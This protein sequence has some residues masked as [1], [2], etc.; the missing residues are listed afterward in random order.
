MRL[1]RC[2]TVSR[3]RRV[4]PVRDAGFGVQLFGDSGFGVEP[5]WDSGF[6]KACPRCRVEPVWDSGLRERRDPVSCQRRAEP[7][8][9][10]GLV[11]KAHRLVYHSTLGSRVIKRE[12][13]PALPFA[14]QGMGLRVQ[15]SGRGV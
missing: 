11:S 2:D 7:A 6:S 14:I 5:F 9:R 12:E 15:E 3:H 4:E 1:E 10:G 8:V 13:E